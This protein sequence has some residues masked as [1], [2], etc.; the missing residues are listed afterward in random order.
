MR[1]VKIAFIQ[2]RRNAG[3]TV[4]DLK[5]V[6]QFVPAYINGNAQFVPM[7]YVIRDLQTITPNMEPK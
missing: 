2:R 5:N 4:I 7:D 1:R 6:G 3:P